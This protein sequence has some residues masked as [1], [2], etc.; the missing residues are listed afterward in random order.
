MIR[1]ELFDKRY[2]DLAQ[3]SRDFDVA[4]G[5][6]GSSRGVD[7][8]ASGTGLPG[9]RWRMS[10]SSIV[11]RRTEPASGVLARA[12]FDVTTSI[13]TVI[14]QSFGPSW[15]VGLSQRYATGRPFTP[16]TAATHDA[17]RD[18]WVPQYGA[19]M[20]ERLPAVR[21]VDLGLTHLRRIGAQ[22]VV[23]YSSVTNVFDRENV[24][25]YRYSQDYTLRIPIRSMFKRSYYVGFS[26]N[27]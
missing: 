15:H 11:A 16:V 25:M 2:R 8:F 24:F 13:A 12:P 27:H 20:S 9:M 22:N 14:N 7:V 23:M 4:S 6:V 1:L 3:V 19:P 26:F 17:A 10:L 21:R 5:G 18:V